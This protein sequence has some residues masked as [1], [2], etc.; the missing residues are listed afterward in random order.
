MPHLQIRDPK[1]Y[2]IFFH[3]RGAER[4]KKKVKLFH[5]QK[6]WVLT[7]FHKEFSLYSGVIMRIEALFRSKEDR[8]LEGNWNSCQVG[9]AHIEAYLTIKAWD[10]E[11]LFL[12]K[13]WFRTLKLNSATVGKEVLDSF[14]KIKFYLTLTCGSN[15][16]K[17]SRMIE[18]SWQKIPRC[19]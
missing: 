8:R 19:F 5:S 6:G 13:I 16:L 7:K 15:F 3:A 11:N 14:L 17:T 12:V 10:M 18:N 2:W 1:G 4:C 9:S